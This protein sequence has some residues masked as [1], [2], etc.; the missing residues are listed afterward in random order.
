[1]NNSTPARDRHSGEAGSSLI[2]TLFLAVF[3]IA[4]VAA[5]GFRVARDT[6]AETVVTS[7]TAVSDGPVSIEVLNRSHLDIRGF[8]NVSNGAEVDAWAKWCLGADGRLGV[9]AA[10]GGNKVSYGKASAYAPLGDEVRSLSG[11][12]TRSAS[13][14][15]EDV[16][17][18]TFTCS[19]S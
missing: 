13:T 2:E 14:I 10:I 8:T 9:D 15:L 18:I 12:F 7:I 3:M 16:E 11:G 19:R 4:M 17:D 6:A 5:I 1:M